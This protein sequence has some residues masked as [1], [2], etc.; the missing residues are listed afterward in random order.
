MKCL[1]YIK[2]ALILEAYFRVY[3]GVYMIFVTV[4]THEQAFNRLLICLDKLVEKGVVK[5]E[6]ICQKGYTEYEPINYKAVK[7][8][9]YDEIINNIKKARIVITHGGPSS[10][11]SVLAENKIPIVFPRKKEFNEHVNDHQVEFVR[12]VERIKSNIIVAE[13]ESELIDAI[14]NYNEKIKGM[15]KV[16]ETNNKKFNENLLKQIRELF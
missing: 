15:N 14:T 13:N 11:L 16:D 3:G 1:K 6:I 8:M 10:F 12:K 2:R 5:E 4:G 7:L 9:S